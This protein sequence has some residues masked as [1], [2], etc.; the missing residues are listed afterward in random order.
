M[1]ALLRLRPAQLNLPRDG[2]SGAVGRVEW[3]NRATASYDGDGSRILLTYDRTNDQGKKT[4]VDVE[5]Q[6]V[7]VPCHL[8]GERF[9]VSCPCCGG[10]VLILYV[11]GRH[12]ICRNCTRLRYRSQTIDCETRV[13]IAIRR[14]LDQILPAVDPNRLDLNWIP[15]RPLGMRNR[16]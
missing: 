15:E 12:L 4:A 3:G 8:G 2:T 11:F 16:T 6:L 9:Y 13:T 10:K 7:R 1:S 14:P 5:L